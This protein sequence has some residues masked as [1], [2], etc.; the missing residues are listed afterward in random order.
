M[1]ITPASLIDTIK[2]YP[3]DFKPGEKYYYSNSGFFI[4]G[5][6]VE[7]VSGKKLSEYLTETFFK[8]LGMNSTGIHEPAKLLENEAYGYSYENGKVVKALKNELKDEF[9][10]VKK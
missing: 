1:S 9:S 6:I 4:L 2:A 8:P 7:K 5:Y 3:L 10:K